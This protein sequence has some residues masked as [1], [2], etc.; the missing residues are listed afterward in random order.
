MSFFDSWIFMFLMLLL[1]VAAASADV[2][3]SLRFPEYGGL[4]ITSLRRDKYGYF[5]IPKEMIISGILIAIAI[6]FHGLE[7]KSWL[8][9]LGG[10][11]ART[12]MYFHNTGKN[13]NCRE[14]ADRLP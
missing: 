5:S 4:E 13:Q 3:T 8:I 11:V 12:V 1:Y 9:L 7:P 14:H 10:I 2:F 6:A